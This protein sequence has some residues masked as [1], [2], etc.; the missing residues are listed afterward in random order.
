MFYQLIVKK[1]QKTFI[2]TQK[3]YQC[4]HSLTWLS[5][6]G[7]WYLLVS[8][9]G[10]RE[11]QALIRKLYNNRTCKQAFNLKTVLFRRS[12]RAEDILGIF[13]SPISSVV[14]EVV[15]NYKWLALCTTLKKT[16]KTPHTHTRKQSVQQQKHFFTALKSPLVY[17]GL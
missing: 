7:L 6:S 10:R 1:K 11:S 9:H 4:H 12:S 13:T 5:S 16:K 3:S 8:K 15:S 14:A 17:T 2:L